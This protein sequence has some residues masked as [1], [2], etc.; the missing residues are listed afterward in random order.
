MNPFTPR[1]RM[2]RRWLGGFLLLAWLIA[3]MAAAAPPVFSVHDIDGDGYLDRS[4]YAAFLGRFWSRRAH[5]AGSGPPPLAFDA[6][7]GDRDGRL[8]EDELLGALDLHLQHRRW[9]HGWRSAPR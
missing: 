5:N 7:D 1:S 4:E 8:S 9:R 6:V 2:R 3:G